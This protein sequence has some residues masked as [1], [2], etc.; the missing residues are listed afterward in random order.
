MQNPK[1]HLTELAAFLEVSVT[2]EFI[3]E[4]VEKCSFENLKNNKFDVSTIVD[5]NRKSTL[6]RKGGYVIEYC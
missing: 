2:G 5:P 1:E 6:F 3:D 4:V